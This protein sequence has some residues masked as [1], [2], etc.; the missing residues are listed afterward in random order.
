MSRDINGYN[1]FGLTF[2]DTAYSATLATTTDTTLT[3]PSSI[4]LGKQ[5]YGTNATG[6]MLAVFTFDPGT[7]VWVA[8]G[9]TAGVP[10]GASFAATSSE[11]NPAARLVSGGDVLHFYTSGTGVNVSV[12]FYSVS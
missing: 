2:T 4:P 7:A 6:Q 10:A 11:L 5:G 3:V 1:G 9:A 12:A 8:N